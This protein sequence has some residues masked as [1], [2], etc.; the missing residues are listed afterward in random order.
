[1]I[2]SPLILRINRVLNNSCMC[3]CHSLSQRFPPFK[4]ISNCIKT[5]MVKDLG[6]LLLSLI[7]AVL[8][9]QSLFF[10]RKIHFSRKSSCHYQIILKDST[11]FKFCDVILSVFLFRWVV[12]LYKFTITKFISSAK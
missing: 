2:Q 3:I 4:N 11:Y 1:M 6:L 8:K 9:T 5:F 12:I 10:P 7:Y